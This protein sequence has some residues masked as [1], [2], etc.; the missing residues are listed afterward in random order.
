MF[1]AA[2]CCVALPVSFVRRGGLES[3]DQ[4]KKRKEE[5]GEEGGEEE[6]GRGESDDEI[7]QYGSRRPAGEHART[8]T[9][10]ASGLQQ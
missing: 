2:L 5:E 9:I 8:H 6:R 3:R 1:A 4:N 10:G 7:K